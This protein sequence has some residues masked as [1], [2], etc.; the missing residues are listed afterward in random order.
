MRSLTQKLTR[1]VLANQDAICD[2]KRRR[3]CDP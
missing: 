2:T 3:R 1:E